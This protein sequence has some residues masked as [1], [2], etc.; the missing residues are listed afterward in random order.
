MTKHDHTNRSLAAAAGVIGYLAGKYVVLRLRH[1]NEIPDSEWKNA[2][3][4]GDILWNAF[5][6]GTTA[7]LDLGSEQGTLARLGDVAGYVGG[8]NVVYS[9]LMNSRDY[10]KSLF[11]YDLQ[12]TESF[13][14][15][16][17]EAILETFTD[18]IIGG[19]GGILTGGSEYFFGSLPEP[20]A[21]GFGIFSNTVITGI[22][23]IADDQ[24]D[25]DIDL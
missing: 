5:L 22:T 6:G 13:T 11:G 17:S 2:E 15:G 21:I 23:I 24:I 8:M 9:T 20:L 1:G 19:I 10:I 12:G 16:T 25:V 3:V 7:T 4:V 18:Y 14:E